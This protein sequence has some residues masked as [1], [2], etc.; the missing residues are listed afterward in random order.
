MPL[1][2]A[3]DHELVI[4]KILKLQIDSS[5]NPATFNYLES[6]FKKA[7]EISA[8]ALLI[9]M[10]TPGGL[11]STTKKILNLFGDSKIPVIVWVKPEGSSATSAGAI[12]ASGSHALFMS[13]GT[14]I[15]AATPVTM[16]K[17]IDKQSDLRAKA[18][19]DLVALVKS[20]S[21]A[22]G[23]NA[24]AYGKMV[25][26]A[27]SY[28]SA[29]ALKEKLIDGIANT[30][31][32][33]FEK[34]DSKTIHILGKDL[35]LKLNNPVFVDFAMDLGQSLLNTFANPN[36]AYILFLIGAAL[37]YLELQAPGGFIAGGLGVVSLILA[38]IG[39]QVLP[40]NIGALGL[41]VVSFILF[42]MEI[43]I[44]SYGILSIAGLGAL[45]S[46]SLFLYRS[47]NG[48][49]ELSST[50]IFSAV[51]AIVLFL[52][53]I[54]YIF[55]K[56]RDNIG[57]EKFN[58]MS[59]KRAKVLSQDG[60]IFQVKVGGEIWKAQSSKALEI[61]SEVEILGRDPKLMTLII[62]K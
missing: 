19:N 59:G 1:V 21:E 31:K 11:V 42:V 4:N 35:T 52:G 14:N 40:L 53:M 9:T 3:Q 22:R 49:I 25:S 18:V 51:G 36:L 56:E 54:A 61:G 30:D 44:T 45:I 34:L 60:D 28:D 6:G 5:I 37:I 38:G 15:G 46:G 57:K 26:E 58:D 48:Y 41:I 7:H 23:R 43:Y 27:A 47:E 2:Q 20:L 10:N 12:I 50:V 24:K 29:T 32:E 55:I 17:D 33:L 39:F 8:D 13:E 62:K 16:G